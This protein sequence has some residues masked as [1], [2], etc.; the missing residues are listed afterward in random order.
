MGLY[1]SHEDGL[2]GEF[3]R[4]KVRILEGDKI[5]Q[6][7]N[8]EVAGLVPPLGQLVLIFCLSLYIPFPYV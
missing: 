2:A 1:G 4:R 8:H 5:A 3:R 7:I 6:I